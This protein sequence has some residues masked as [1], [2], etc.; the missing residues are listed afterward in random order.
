MSAPTPGDEL[1]AV[2]TGR[3]PGLTGNRTGSR[4]LPSPPRCKLCAAPF[5]RCRRRR[6]AAPRVRPLSR[7]PG[8][9]PE[10]HRHFTKSG[11]TRRRDPGHAAVRGHP[12]VDR[13]SANACRRRPSTTSS[14]ASIR[15]GSKT[16]L[17]HDGLVDKLVGDEVIGLV[18]R[19]RQS[20]RPCA[21]RRRGGDR[22]HGTGRAG[23]R[24]RRRGRSR[25]GRRSIPG[26]P[27][28]A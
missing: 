24:D 10:L 2:L 13:R 23:R 8:P 14:S 9:L 11:I 25:S 17:D 18:L 12:R 22:P 6:P 5:E 28:S 1:R 21:R 4:R 3:A 7:Q 26:W 16:I 15:F 27:T 19:R 20:A